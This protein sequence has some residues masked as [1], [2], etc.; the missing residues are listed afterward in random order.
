MCTGGYHYKFPECQQLRRDLTLFLAIPFQ[1]DNEQTSFHRVIS[2]N[3][4]IC[5]QHP[6]QKVRIGLS[7]KSWRHTIVMFTWEG[8]KEEMMTPGNFVLS[9]DSFVKAKCY[10]F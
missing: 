6:S 2:V 4:F 1:V 7:D 8:A 3:T 10:H 5:I 9:S